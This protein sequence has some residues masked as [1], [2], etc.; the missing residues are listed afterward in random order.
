MQR[1]IKSHLILLFTL[2]TSTI[3]GVYI[4]N[5]TGNP[6][7]LIISIFGLAFFPILAIRLD[8]ARWFFPA[9]AGVISVGV[10]SIL[11]T[12]GLIIGGG[13]PFEILMLNTTS[14]DGFWNFETE[15]AVSTLLFIPLVTM[16]QEI[17]GIDMAFSHHVVTSFTTLPIILFSYLL[18][19]H[20]YSDKPAFLL[21]VFILFQYNIFSI[22]IEGIRVP[23]SIMSFAFLL[24]SV[25]A[26]KEK[27]IILASII[28]V[29]GHYYGSAFFMAFFLG[30]AWVLMILFN[31]W[32][33]LVPQLWLVS[34]PHYNHSDT[35]GNTGPIRNISFIFVLI[36][37]SL[38]YIWHAQDHILTHILWHL[39]EISIS[40][41]GIFDSSS[42]SE[43]G[44]TEQSNLLQLVQ[45][46]I[47]MILI[48]GV[49]LMGLG[50]LYLIINNNLTESNILRSM[51]L[52][53]LGLSFLAVATP[54]V[55]S[56]SLGIMRVYQYSVFILVIGLFVGV[57]ILLDCSYRL[58]IIKNN[59]HNLA[60]IV[61][62]VLI[63][64]QFTVHG[65]IAY[66][67]TDDGPK[68]I[69]YNNEEDQYQIWHIWDGERQ[70]ASFLIEH[71][72]ND[73]T[74]HGDRYIFNRLYI[75]SSGE[76]P[77]ANRNFFLGDTHREDPGYIYLRHQNVV[78][79]KVA[80]HSTG[81]QDVE[82]ID[83]YQN[84]LN[85]NLIYSNGVSKIQTYEP[86]E[87][88]TR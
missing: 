21:S 32:G 56:D 36:T 8:P 23:L 4:L 78:H 84:L 18:F 6:I 45:V 11:V 59:V 30:S 61:V 43:G 77:N 57:H 3:L 67:I 1:R 22:G 83:K 62:A 5:E 68:V 26:L 29:T 41:D 16:L 53:V 54:F 52:T 51:M 50:S 17:S 12:R 7:T 69:E 37:F 39:S 28:T 2:V 74:I 49:G 86:P 76:T 31:R 48:I 9:A 25:I 82:P 27:Y 79:D 47:A 85:N 24:Y 71:N 80:P 44:T 20:L 14:E 73:R 19:R 88:N 63:I 58:G 40:I 72:M 64:L 60:L 55:S 81:F 34:N 66:Q 35:T 46:Y 10:L 13:S 75:E 38:V 42:G 33:H 70:G 87:N 15:T 65:G